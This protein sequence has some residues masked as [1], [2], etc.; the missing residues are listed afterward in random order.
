MS[1]RQSHRTSGESSRRGFLGGI[2]AL[3]AAAA[4]SRDVPAAVAARVTNDE[5]GPVQRIES[6]DGSISVTLE[7]AD[8]IPSYEVACNGTTYIGPSTLGFDFQNQPSFG[9]SE[10][11]ESGAG[12]E[13]TGTEREST[14]EEWE[15]VW[16]AVDH[17]SAEYR[18]LVVGLA[19]TGEPGRSANLEV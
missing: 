5:D 3:V 2:G 19:E 13:V 8:G 18:S 16:G 4:Y 7:V 10:E 9:A 6:P 11:G 1:E 15:P 17:V 14:T 12:L